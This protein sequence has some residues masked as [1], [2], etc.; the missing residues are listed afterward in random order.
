M[1]E[2]EREELLKL[3]AKHVQLQRLLKRHEDYE[4]R[5]RTIRK[6]GFL[7]SFE[8]QE[9]QNLKLKKLKGKEKLL[10]LFHNLRRPSSGAKHNT[11]NSRQI[12]ANYAAA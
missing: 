5:I 2:E 6:R 8:Q 3:A 12:A 9:V 1:N 10:T 11:N 7:T 4:E